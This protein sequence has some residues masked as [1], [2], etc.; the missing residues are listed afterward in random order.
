EVHV[1]GEVQ[2]PGVYVL[3]EGTRVTD[4]I[5]SAGGFAAD[6]DRSTINLA[7]VLRDGDQVHVY[8]TGESSQRININTADAWLLEALPGIGEKTAEKIIAHRTENGP[9][10]SVDE[11]KEAGIVGEATFE[12]IKD[13]IAVR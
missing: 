13:M 5:E 7:K 2:N 12:K 11:L 6:A 1:S 10:E 3:N 4:A 9:F 8:K